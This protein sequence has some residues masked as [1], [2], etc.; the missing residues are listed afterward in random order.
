MEHVGTR[1]NDSSPQAYYDEILQGRTGHHDA[2]IKELKQKYGCTQ[3]SQ[4]VYSYCLKVNK[5]WIKESL[6]GNLRTL[7]FSRNT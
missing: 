7:H 6:V 2:R 4:F 5:I 3:T 1:L